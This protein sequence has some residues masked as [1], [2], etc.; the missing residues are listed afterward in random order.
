MDSL[1]SYKSMS[2]SD[3]KDILRTM[4]LPTSGSKSVLIKRI[5][6]GRKREREE[7]NG[8]PSK[9]AKTGTASLTEVAEWCQM[10]IPDLKHLLGER[11]LKKSGNK[12]EL[13]ARLYK[14][15]KM[16]KEEEQDVMDKIFY[17][18]QALSEEFSR[19]SEEAG[20]GHRGN[21]FRLVANLM[22]Y[23]PF[24]IKSG[25]EAQKLK[26]IGKSAGSKIQEFLDAKENGGEG[27]NDDKEQQT[28]E[29][30]KE[31]ISPTPVLKTSPKKTSSPR[32]ASSFLASKP[33]PEEK[34][35]R[36]EQTLQSK[37]ID[38]LSKD[39]SDDGLAI[40]YICSQ[41]GGS[42]EDVRGILD[43]LTEEGRAYSTCD[44]DHFKL[45]Q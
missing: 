19:L 44:E 4:S 42:E 5:M 41:T 8:S 33:E 34:V 13:V 38:V 45:D 7:E 43:A 26:G 14:G 25:K 39:D 30:K 21:S 9:K 15:E 22:K 3:L 24:V 29:Q 32:K 1:Q 37:V 18:N 23:Y 31:N 6:T 27:G 28:Q 20:P 36:Q 11:G 2:S 40:Q 17:K 12:G 16:T 35:E 10:K